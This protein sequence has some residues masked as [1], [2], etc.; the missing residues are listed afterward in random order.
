MLLGS[1]TPTYAWQHSAECGVHMHEKQV[2][3]PP[4]A[5]LQKPRGLA[6]DCHL[7]SATVWRMLWNPGVLLIVKVRMGSLQVF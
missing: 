5:L 7:G 2:R 3:V 4:F 1:R 6:R